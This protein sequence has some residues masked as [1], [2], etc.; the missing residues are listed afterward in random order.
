MLTLDCRAGVRVT[1]AQNGW[2]NHPRH[3]CDKMWRSK[4]FMPAVEGKPVLQ[5]TVRRKRRANFLK[6][7]RSTN[8]ITEI[9]KSQLFSSFIP[10]SNVIVI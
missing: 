10:I 7:V 1:V 4:T 6:T 3:T 2:S 9:P 8:K 5:A